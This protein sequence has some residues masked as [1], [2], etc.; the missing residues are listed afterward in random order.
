M[1]LQAK[2]AMFIAWGPDLAF[3]YNDAYAPIFGQKH[4]HAFG[5]PFAE[6]W[7]DIWPQIKPLVDST[8]AG[9]GS[10]HEDLLIPVERRGYREEAYFS[11]SYNPAYGDDGAVAGMFCA[12]TETTSKVLTERRHVAE[13]ENLRQMF[14]QA[15]GMMVMLRGPDHVFEHANAAYYQLVGHRDLINKPVREALPELEGQ[16]FFELLDGAYRSGEPFVGHGVRAQFRPT[17]GAPL[18]EHFVDFIYQPIRD[19]EG[20][21]TGIF[22][23][24]FDVTERKRAEEALRES[25]EFN[26][27]VLESSS[28]CIKVLD[29]DAKLQFMSP[30]A[31]Q[32]MEVEDFGAIQGCDWRTF[33]SGP[34]H[35]K[36]RQAVETA[37]AGG[38]GRFQGPTPTMKGTPRWWDVAVTPILGADGRVEKLLSVSR[39]ITVMKQAEEALRESEQ[40][41][42]ITFENVQVGV[43]ETD[44][45]GRF[46]RVNETFCRIIG[47]EPD[48]LEGRAFRDLTHPEDRDRDVEGLRQL[49]EGEIT[50][51]HVEKRYF[52]NDGGVVW[53]DLRARCVH[54][55]RGTPLIV[56]S[57]IQDITERKSAEIALRES[58]AR[59][60]QERALL[61]TLIDNLPVG[62]C[63][64]D[65]GGKALLSNPAFRR[66]L[67]EDEPMPSRMP[68]GEER[69]VAW[70]EDGQR[71]PRDRYPGARALRGEVEPGVE[72]L[73]RPKDGPEVWT[74]VAGIPLL[75]SERQVIAALVVVVDIDSQKRAQEALQR[76]NQNL[77]GE[78]AARTAERDKIWQNS[79]ELMAVFSNDGRRLAINPAWSRVLGYDED[80]LL[81]K[82]MHEITHPDDREMLK[83]AVQKLMQGEIVDPFED[84]LRHAN[85]SYRT[86][87]WTGVPGEGVFYAIGR[88]VTEHRRTEEALRQAQKMEAIGQLTGGV[89]H[90]FNNLLTIIRSSTDLLR[91]P[92][93]SEERQR[94]YIDAITDTVDRA[95]RLTGQLL[96]F[97]RRQALKPEV[98]DVAERVRAVS[99]MVR[100]IVGSR[101]RITTDVASESC[102]VEADVAQF[103]TALVNM[104]VNARDAME[105]EGTLT[106]RVEVT[107]QMPALRGHAGGSGDFVAV[108]LSDTGS[109]IEPDKISQIFEPFFTTKEVGKGTGLGLSQVYGFVKQ[110]GGD[111]DVKSEVGRGTTFILYLP[112]VQSEPGE[113]PILLGD[114]PFE[115]GGGRRVLVVEDNTEVGQFST[116]ILEDLGYV[117][118]WAANADEALRLLSKTPDGFDIVFSDVVMPGMSGVDLGHEIRRRYPDLPVVLTSGYSHVLAEEGRHG[119]E[120][121]HKPYAA[122]E[123][124]RVLQKMMGSKRHQVRSA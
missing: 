74:R 15:P 92:N 63:F 72:F 81:N 119:F 59:L 53:A 111:V 33:W 9:E 1:I 46:R 51:Y 43:C 79:N 123:L 103:E 80:S 121:L 20:Q 84:R 7:A 6:V 90:D 26:R 116:Q 96:A 44:L 61:T 104:A 82:P 85:G 101:I 25:E 27:R 40:R 49:V 13:R 112:R 65:P 41:L 78:V 118:T 45:D 71:L 30:G 64:L 83:A 122:E 77:E 91:R 8:L 106:V 55:E 21:V 94:R 115:A 14:E 52:H 50:V 56:V 37:L 38:T 87:S 11:F 113:I 28:D 19:A 39:D 108:S 3:L 42:A 12:A 97:A 16:G 31:M 75:N 69:W 100:T 5:R 67:P 86:I 18:E 58:E 93:L 60:S 76:L 95:S 29:A 89:A 98:F 66:F 107:S 110:S 48:E 102:F 47:Y 4:P 54:D 114:A 10:W 23:E 17:P 117:T 105:G 73:Y 88:D 57:T 24:G 124:S 2:Q 99:E 62:V 68:D 22:V 34:E 120:L 70:D 32:V 36:A 35:E 109:G